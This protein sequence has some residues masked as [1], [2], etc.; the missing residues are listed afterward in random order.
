MCD[1]S[2]IAWVL[3]IVSLVLTC[4]YAY[5][6]TPMLSIED[7]SV[8]AF[9]KTSDHT[10][11]DI[12]FDLKL[13]NMNMAIGL[14]YDDPFSLAF[15]YYPLEEPNQKYVWVC[16]VP[17]FYQ[18]NGKTKHIRALMGKKSKNIQL[19][20]SVVAVD[21]DEED[22]TQ[23]VVD[24]VHD[25][26]AP[27]AAPFYQGNGETNQVR[28][29]L[30]DQLQLSST[31]VG[32]QDASEE[33]LAESRQELVAVVKAAPAEVVKFRI[34][35]AVNYRFKLLADSSTHQLELGGD[36]MVDANTGNRV[37][38]GSIKLVESDAAAGGPVVLMVLF[39]S[40]LLIMCV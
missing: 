27:K 20:S 16:T 8:P 11:Q 38:T 28:S 23:E 17:A 9:N 5:P 30:R 12:Y 24:T 13:R 19:P 10:E 21:V 25:F 40:V 2:P 29:L 33:H 18:G 37:S 31:L 22:D 35:V 32:N 3:A 36:V 14:Y 7:F 15:S 34:Q 1:I 6:N 39:T 26:L 4:L